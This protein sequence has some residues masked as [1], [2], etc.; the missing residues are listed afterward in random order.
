MSCE[1]HVISKCSNGTINKQTRRLTIYWAVRHLLGLVECFCMMAPK[2]IQIS[3]AKAKNI[4]IGAIKDIVKLFHTKSMS[5]AK[6]INRPN[7]LS[8][9]NSFLKDKASRL[10]VFP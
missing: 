9:V 1:F 6:A 5:P 10:A 4:P 2:V 8:F 7:N 3:A